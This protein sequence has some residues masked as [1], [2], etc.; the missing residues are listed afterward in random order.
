MFEHIKDALCVVMGSRAHTMTSM[1]AS[2]GSALLYGIISTSMAF[3]NKAVLAVYEFNYPMT[4]MTA[5]MAVTFLVCKFNLS[6]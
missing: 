4:I 5:Q 2:V 1:A 3:L 6:I